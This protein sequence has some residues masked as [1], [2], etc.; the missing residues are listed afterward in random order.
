[1][2]NSLIFDRAACASETGIRARSS[3]RQAARGRQ[4]GVR[5]EKAFASARK[6]VLRVLN[7]WDIA[8]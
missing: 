1:M 3:G 4:Q 2:T 5:I 8:R 7:I 6:G